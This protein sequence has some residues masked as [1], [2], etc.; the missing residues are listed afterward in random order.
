MGK[1]RRN[2]QQGDAAMQNQQDISNEELKDLAPEVIEDQAAAGQAEGDKSEAGE[3][4]SVAGEAVE[5]GAA[6]AAV[7]GEPESDQGQ[8]EQEAAPENTEVSENVE[9]DAAGSA[10]AAEPAPEPAPVVEEA[11]EAIAPVEVKKEEPAAPA[12][13]SS[14]NLTYLQNIR[15][16]GTPVQKQALETIE[17]FCKRMTPRAPITAQ[18]AIEAQRDLLDFITVILRKDYEE[19][20]K[21]WAVLL[22]YFAEHHGDRP[23]AKDYTALSEYSTSR[24]LDAWTDDDRANAYNNLVTLLRVTRNTETR[25]Q[26]VKRIRLDQIAP[27]FLNARS[28]DNLQRFYG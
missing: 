11:K 21:G 19:F 20:R 22:V 18:Q 8:A 5:G 23:S 4:A 1:K 2:N 27:G 15:E 3:T 13:A 17:L 12:V 24:H 6:P 9:S 16:N 10:P 26:D 28:Q 7:E 14:E 25:K